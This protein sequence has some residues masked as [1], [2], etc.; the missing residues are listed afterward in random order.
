MFL[1]LRGLNTG[2]QKIKDSQSIEYRVATFTFRRHP[3]THVIIVQKYSILYLI[4]H[5]SMA[6]IEFPLKSVESRLVSKWGHRFPLIHSVKKW[7]ILSK[8]QSRQSKLIN[9]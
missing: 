1:F 8:F 3:L 7:H 4:N 2:G 9:N 5:E 6:L